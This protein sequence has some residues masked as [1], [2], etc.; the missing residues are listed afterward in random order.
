MKSSNNSD[1]KT[2]I[3]IHSFEQASELHNLIHNFYKNYLESKLKSHT[4]AK[5]QELTGLH[6]T[7]FR[8][9]LVRDSYSSLKTHAEKLNESLIKD[10]N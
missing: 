10:K 5:L 1:S 4:Y 6:Q 8:K 9:A 7:G 3:Q 2:N